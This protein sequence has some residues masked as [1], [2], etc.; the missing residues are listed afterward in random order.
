MESRIQSGER[1]PLSSTQNDT[2]APGRSTA[3]VHSGVICVSFRA[4]K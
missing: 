3:C 1:V 4:Q 2:K